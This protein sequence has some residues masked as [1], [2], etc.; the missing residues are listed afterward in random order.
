MWSMSHWQGQATG[1]TLQICSDIPL[2]EAPV[3]ILQV[4]LELETESGNPRENH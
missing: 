1:Q 2:V 3:S 4:N